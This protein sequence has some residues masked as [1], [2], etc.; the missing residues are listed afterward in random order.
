[1]ANLPIAEFLRQRLKEY[2]P[3]FDVRKGTGFEKL[4]F[5]PMQFIVQP[6]RDE[7]NDIRTGQS[8]R[9][10]LQTD[11]PDNFSEEAVDDLVS[12]VFVDR[13]PGSIS[14]GVVRVYYDSPVSREYS[15]ESAVF[16]GNNGK[17]YVNP[18]PYSISKAQ[19]SAQIE[20]GQYYFDIPVVSTE[21][22]E[23]TEIEPG[24][25]VSLANDP[26][27]IAVT[28]KAKISGG[29]SREKNTE[30]LT[31][32]KNSI[33][34][35]DL[36]TGKGFNAIL[37]E[38]FPG[39]I[40]E[41]R[42]I[43]M[44]DKEMMRDI[45]FN[46][47]IGGKVDGYFAAPK[48]LRGSTDFI[49]LLIDTTR[50]AKSTT[51]VQLIGTTYSPLGNPGIDR[52]GGLEPIVRQIKPKTLASFTSP[53]DLTNPIDLTG[54]ERIKMTIDGNT[55]EFRVAG[56]SVSATNRNEIVALINKAFGYDYA[57]PFGSTFKI[58]SK[59]P[60]VDSEVI[61]TDPD[62]GGSAFTAL[63]GTT[64]PYESYG[65]GPIEFLEGIHYEI[66]DEDGELRRIVGSTVLSS[67][68]GNNINGNVL[69]QTGGI[70]GPVAV[71]DILTI[72]SSNDSSNIKDY[73]IIN[74]NP[75]D[76][77]V[78]SPFVTDANVTYTIRR[79]GI[80]DKEVVF[81]EYYFNPLSIDIGNLVKL[82]PDGKTRGVRPGRENYTIK[83][84]AFLRVA[85]IEVIDPLTKEGTGQFLEGK[86]GF[87]QGGFGQGAFGV[88]S[89][90]DYRLIVNEPHDRFSAFEDSYI[91]LNSGFAGLSLKVSYDYVPEVVSLHNFVRSEYE[92]VLDADI[93]MK[94]FIPAYVEGTI[95]YSVDI[96]DSSI[97]DNETLQTMLRE[98]ISAMPSGE[99]LHFSDIKQFIA[100]KT[101]PFDKY[102]SFVRNFTLKAYIHN[103]DGSMT[104][105][106]GTELLTMPTSEPFPKNTKRVQS[107][108][109]TH[110]VAKE[111]LVLER[112]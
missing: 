51:N 106:S 8:M 91:V 83:D 5:Q 36:V 56:I 100:R 64:A 92:R 34:V 74:V 17:F 94:H 88:G 32:A 96:T 41:I 85:S 7:A 9:R 18:T 67:S 78:D 27:V 46:A 66:N 42:P 65:E 62:T 13:V 49:S 81:V 57:I 16:S 82:D 39:L 55:R 72:I 68:T 1:M 98:F 103:T 71:N 90:A 53:V 73:R 22:G 23:E 111:E 99:P 30:L 25:V 29:L 87:G 79:T 59:N 48:V 35:R 75:G 21:F 15:A 93:L 50:Q 89:S 110:W 52:S 45:L 28:N 112:I 38:N 47:H 77:T 40:R 107:A 6:L 11:E 14:S 86:G 37:Y 4:F 102:K 43:G 108:R 61:I 24:G 69:T 105:I 109:I 97:P 101:D 19:M 80:K 3:T 31:R 26:D 95:Q 70:F 2:D 104:V 44:G 58:I 10:I 60:G 63:F 54:A 20:S 84:L 76:I 33:A 12:N